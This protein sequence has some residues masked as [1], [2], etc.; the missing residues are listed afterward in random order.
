MWMEL[1]LVDRLLSAAT[2]LSIYLSTYISIY[3]SIYLS[4]YEA[5]SSQKNFDAK[6]VQI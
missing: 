1:V 3:Q 5:K 4:I 2:C 6:M